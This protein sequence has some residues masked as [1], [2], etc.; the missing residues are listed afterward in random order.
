[1]RFF[2]IIVLIGVSIM[3][4]SGCGKDNEEVSIFITDD[5]LDPTEIRE[6][7]QQILQEK[8]GEELKVKVSTSPIYNEQKILVEY[9]ARE[10]EIFILPEDVM[11]LYARDGTHIVLD[12]EFDPEK[13]PTGVFEAGVINKDTDEVGM[14]THLFAI[15]IS[16]MKIFQD[17]NYTREG[18]FATIPVSTDSME[19]SIKLLKAMIE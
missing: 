15:P 12:E 16:E 19:D 13:Y 10:H 5:F 8:L 1:M 9:A 18:L 2:R 3:I 4:L 6:P 7:L 11:K 17:L 14:E